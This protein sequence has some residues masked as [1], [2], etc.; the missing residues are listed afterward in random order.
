MFCY[1][2]IVFHLYI[3]YYITICNFK[4]IIS[5]V[6]SLTESVNWVK[7]RVKE[8]IKQKAKETEI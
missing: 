8:K 4:D 7:G 1:L 2:L 3:I 6:L 5:F